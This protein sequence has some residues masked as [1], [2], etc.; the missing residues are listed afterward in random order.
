MNLAFTIIFAVYA[1]VFLLVGLCSSLALF[2]HKVKA[3]TSERLE[4][5]DVFD[6]AVL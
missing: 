5:P 4:N 3:M 1:G 6:P 2:T